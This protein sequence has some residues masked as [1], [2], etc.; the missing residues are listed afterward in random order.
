MI[1]EAKRE[2][3]RRTL[4][5][6]LDLLNEQDAKDKI[7]QLKD[8]LK[9]EKQAKKDLKKLG[10]KEKKEARQKA[11]EQ[12][13]TLRQF[14]QLCSKFPDAPEC[15]DKEAFVKETEQE[16]KNVEDATKDLQKPPSGVPDKKPG[17]SVGAEGAREESKLCQLKGDK[18]YEYKVENEVWYARKKGTT[19]WNSLA[20]DKYAGARAKLDKGCPG[21]RKTI[22]KQNTDKPKDDI[23]GEEEVSSV[24]I[25]HDPDSWKSNI[26]GNDPKKDAEAKQRAKEYAAM[27]YQGYSGN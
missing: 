5:E 23:D 18:T 11:R 3:K 19:K 16:I 1:R 17:D 21:F 6:E 2:L 20:G 14:N 8:A 22:E 10:R 12:R 26:P 9:R 15:A 7:K 27:G 13:K 24:T 4:I 25:E